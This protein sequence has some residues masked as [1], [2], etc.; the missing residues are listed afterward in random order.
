MLVSDR[1]LITLQQHLAIELPDLPVAKLRD[2]P[3]TKEAGEV[4]IVLDADEPE[5][6]EGMHGIFE[7][8]VEL[9]VMV[10]PNDM[11]AVDRRDLLCEIME[12]LQDLAGVQAFVN[13]SQALRGIG[14]KGFHLFDLVIEDG[15][16]EEEGEE[17]VG[18]V[19]LG[20][21]CMGLD[22]A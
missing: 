18:T 21:T 9:R 10:H 15:G 13:D 1:L 14:A 8:A 6:H 4:Q 12:L 7:V 20:A 17:Y 16:W 5:E 22:R 3:D 19:M 2:S 11:T